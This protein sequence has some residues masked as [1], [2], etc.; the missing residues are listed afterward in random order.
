M[1]ILYRRGDATKPCAEGTKIIAHVCN[2]QGAW[3]KGFV[4]AISQRWRQPAEAF[5]RW[6]VDGSGF[7]LGAVQFVQVEPTLWVAN[8]VAQFGLRPRDGTAPIRYDSLKV[9]LEKVAAMAKRLGAT[10][11]MPRIGCGL[12]GG[13]WSLVEATMYGRTCNKLIEGSHG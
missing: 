1:E 11:H 4:L 5:K 2:D 6:F 13:E 9:C 7:E 10:V 8:M 3:G 12:A